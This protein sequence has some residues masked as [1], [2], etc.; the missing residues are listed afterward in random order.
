MEERSR[1]SLLY[2]RMKNRLYSLIKRVPSPRIV[3]KW[4]VYC[5]VYDSYGGTL[6]NK[7]TPLESTTPYQT[8]DQEVL[9]TNHMYPPLVASCL[10]TCHDVSNVNGEVCIPLV[11]IS[12]ADWKPDGDCGIKWNPLQFHNQ[13]RSNPCQSDPW[14]CAN[15]GR[16]QVPLWECE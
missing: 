2:R 8:T 15:E 9:Y 1:Y 5:V 16:V 10:A 14:S 4:K 3:F 12:L 13:Q 7:G 6:W 11:M